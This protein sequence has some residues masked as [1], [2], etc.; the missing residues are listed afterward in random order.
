MP[1]IITPVTCT[2]TISIKLFNS[3]ENK[4]KCKIDEKKTNTSR[5]IHSSHCNFLRTVKLNFTVF[6]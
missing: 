3:K 5:F 4:E 2:C 6:R 1:E